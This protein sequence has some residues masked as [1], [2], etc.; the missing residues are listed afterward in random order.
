MQAFAHLVVMVLD[1]DPAS[2]HVI[3]EMVQAG[4]PDAE[5]KSFNDHTHFL[6]APD[7]CAADL[8]IID[9]RLTNFDGRDLPGLM[10]KACLTKPFLFVSGF[11]IEDRQFDRV[12]NLVHYD[13]VSKPFGL[14]RFVHRVGFMLKTRPSIFHRLQD[15]VFELVAYTPFVALVIDSEFKVRYCNRQTVALLE[16]DKTADIVGR[17]WLDFVP[18]EVAL[19]VIEVHGALITGEV[20]KFEEYVN[21][22]K[23]VNDTRKTVRWF[24][25]PFDGMDGESLT[26][27]IGV[28]VTAESDIENKLRDQFRRTIM[29]DKATIKAVQ[30][31]KLKPLN[32]L[33]CRMPT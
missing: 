17:S 32:S 6:E 28:S 20:A 31:L 3:A 8:F 24:N 25:T 12:E 16:V 26:L 14:R 15:D 19:A 27:S 7:L 23:T 18:N 22:V 4:Y 13:F 2:A 33:S 9:I 21:D 11:P 10:P 29:E 5:V 30:R 1:D